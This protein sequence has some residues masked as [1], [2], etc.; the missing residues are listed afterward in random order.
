MA[1][2]LEM[3]YNTSLL[4]SMFVSYVEGILA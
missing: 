2:Q 1:P 4:I 3:N